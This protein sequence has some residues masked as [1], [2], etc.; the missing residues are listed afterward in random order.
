MK[1]PTKTVGVSFHLSVR[2]LVRIPADLSIDSDDNDQRAEALIYAK[3][4]EYFTGG[5]EIEIP[6]LQKARLRL[7]RHTGPL[8]LADPRDMP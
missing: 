6:G 4:A 8:C 5:A 1:K 3:L 2:A 7:P